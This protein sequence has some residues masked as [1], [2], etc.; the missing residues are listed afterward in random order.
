MC[1]IVGFIGKNIEKNLVDILKKLE[2]RG[3]DS[4][5]I[6]VIEN[7][8]IKCTKSAGNID[9]LE[10]IIMPSGATCG[11]AHTRWATTGMPSVLNAHPH[12]SQNKK[13][14]VVH[15]GIIENYTNLK[16]ELINKNVSFKSDTDT[17]V[18]AQMLEKTKSKGI[19]SL[20]EVC[21]KLEG[22]YALACLNENYN[23]TLFLA[24][25][26][27]PLYVAKT[28]KNIICASDPICFVGFCKYYYA[29]EDGE[30]CTANLKALEF[31]NTNGEK[32][33][34]NKQKLDGM[35]QETNKIKF[36]H[37]MKK[38]ILETNFVLK[39]I[40][41]N[42]LNYNYL[43]KFDK[44][45]INKFNQIVFVGCG[46]AYHAG[47]VG[48]YYIEK[49]AKIR[50]KC[51]IASE[52][53][54]INPLIDENTLC[55]FVSQSGET[56]DTILSLE[57]ASQKGAYT[58][59]LTNV[60]YSS[61]AKKAEYILPIFAGPEIA[62]VSTK[63]FSAQ[64]AVLFLFAKQLETIKTNTTLEFFEKNVKKL[65]SFTFF[66][67]I[68]LKKLANELKSENHI[69]LIG[70]GL[71]Y[72]ACLEASLKFKETSYLN[73][74]AYPSG[75]LKHGFLSLVEIGTYIFAVITNKEM[76]NKTLNSA[77][78]AQCRGAKV[79]L[80]TT[81]SIDKEKLK[82]IYK[83]VKIKNCDSD[84]AII[85]TMIFFQQLCYELALL[86]NINPDKP[87]NLAKSV[88]VE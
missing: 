73:A 78:E 26:K 70:K 12:L 20:I 14:G 66:N 67:N 8:K 33:T 41:Q 40:M 11:I 35:Q 68:F 59:A 34:K 6:A 5:G 54:Y 87:R 45:F 82:N 53:R 57:L 61:L 2:Y 17:E 42:Y 69:F 39:R 3:Y 22:S 18:I 15:N 25:K 64:V 29:L 38:E 72:L 19:F 80:V 37:F 4:S 81:E 84:L 56:L 24:R 60:L 62:V 1:G 31:Y 43:Q 27:S 47:L 74:S 71:D 83:I 16:K 36:K 7:N 46:T 75:E 9:N 51:F 65:Q 23:N 86:K 77:E 13:W 52:F 48:A 76:I 55:I 50:T 63:A 85:Q 58:I 49:F 88:T 44:N 28:S 30:F 21:K 10:K 79:I 32:I